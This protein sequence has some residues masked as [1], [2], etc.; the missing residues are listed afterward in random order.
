MRFE[1]PKCIKMHLRG[2][3]LSWALVGIFTALPRP[4]A[5]FGK[6]KMQKKRGRKGMG[7]KR[8]GRPC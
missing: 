6:G 1:R 8:K 4:L 5:G 2:R 7:R 3:A